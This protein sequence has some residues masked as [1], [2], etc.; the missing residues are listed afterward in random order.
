MSEIHAP[1][2][3]R[4]GWRGAISVIVRLRFAA[5]RRHWFDV[6]AKALAFALDQADVH[7]LPMF[8]LCDAE[9]E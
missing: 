3:P 9:P 7:D 5:V 1:P 4:G 2:I 8:D 6:K